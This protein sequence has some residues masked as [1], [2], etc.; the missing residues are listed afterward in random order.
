MLAERSLGRG[1]N[2]TLVHGWGLGSGAWDPVAQLL[3]EEFTVHLVDLPGYGASPPPAAPA[4][5]GIEA[6]ADALAASLPPR[7]MV[8]GWSLGALV[9]LVCAIRHPR[10]IGRLVLVGATASF[11]QREGWP[12][13]LPPA[14]LEEFS[15]ALEADAAGL[16]KQFSGLIHHGD[17]RGKE[18]MRALRRCLAAGLPADPDSLR[19]GLQTLGAADL[20]LHLPLVEQPVLLIHGSED[21]LMPLA[22]VQALQARLPRAALEVFEGSAHAPFASDPLRFARRVGVFAADAR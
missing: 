19:A 10:R 8:C 14:R 16:L 4:D 21:P 12:S 5:Y 7:A 2:L 13:A 20:R 18:A 15:A 11:V 1:P 6:L 9:A 17:I 3:A 22:A